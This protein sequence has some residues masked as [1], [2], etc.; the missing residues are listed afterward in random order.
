MNQEHPKS[1]RQNLT[2]IL[3][4][5]FG[6][7]VAFTIFYYS[8]VQRIARQ[9]ENYIADVASQRA[10]LL[11]DLF[12]ENQAYIESAAIV[13]E[14]EFD[15]QDVR[16]ELLNVEDVDAVDGAEMLKVR[17]ILRTYEERFAFDHLRLIDLHGRDYTTG[18]QGIAAVVSDRDYFKRG[19]QG[20]TGLTYILDSKVTNERQ[21]GFYSPVRRD[22][23]IIG[24][25]VGFYGENF[26]HRLLSV[27][28]FE[29]DCD[30]LLCDRA[31]AVIYSTDEGI[32][33]ANF[34]DGLEQLTFT[35][36]A[37]RQSIARAFAGAGDTLYGY[38][39]EGGETVGYVA[40]IG[41]GSDFF[42]VLNFPPHAYANMIR[43]AN[44]NG[45]VLLVI[46]IAIFLLAAAFYVLRFLSQKKRLLEETKNSN[47]IHFAMSRLFENFVR[48]NAASRTYH[49][50][51]GMP[52]VGHIP[53]DGPY[54]VFA[55][56]LLERF[57]NPA[58]QEEAREQI[59]LDHLVQT[60]NRGTDI[61]SYNLHAPIREE[62]WFTYNF[63]VVSRD[64]E[65]RVAE[66]LVARQDITKLQ[67]KEEEIRRIL[68]EARDAAEK[69]NQAKTAFLSS[70][71]HDI[72]TPMNAI[73]GFTNIAQDRIGDTDL[74]RDSLN[75]IASS[76]Q[77]LLSLIND[78]LDMSKIES[79][80]LQLHED[81]RN[82]AQIVDRVADM[83]RSQAKDKRLDI[84]FDTDGLAHPRV[85]VDELR[86][87]QVLINITGNA[88][89]YT[90][91][92]GSIAIRAT[93]DPGQAGDGRYCYRFS[94]KDTGIGISEDYL[95][96]IFESFSRETTSTINKIQGTGLGMAITARL[97]ELMGGTI[98]VTSQLDVGSEFVVTLWLETWED[99]GAPA[100][101]EGQTTAADIDLA[102][103]RILLVE[104]NDI[105]AEIAGLVLNGFGME[106]ERAENGQRGLELVRER[107]D[108]WYDAVL[109][110]IQMPVMNGYEATKAIRRLP[111][112]YI[113]RLP[114]IAMSANAYEE[115]IRESLA[116][117][118]NGHIAK[119]FDPQALAMTLHRAIHR[120]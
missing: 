23:E 31:G 1:L 7:V 108:G 104:D 113:R 35:G 13:L 105:N 46:L 6:T 111:G 61:I 82:L 29:Y 44:I 66:F 45:A 58:E 69:G 36:S 92:G 30:V 75:K 80:K 16:A 41:K 67:E 73:I 78:I 40:Y 109:M 112:A 93:E 11:D 12:E 32:D 51:E 42:L 114:I 81:E 103:R 37:D 86:L 27:S 25:V 98:A 19:I 107:G 116:S 99:T 102:G 77:Y 62:E 76:G 91:E 79:G 14:T 53:N 43:N 24:L 119:P 59:S 106:M 5:I 8:N 28:L 17:D 39:A 95:P 63:I 64:G 110:D 26:I 74:V 18:E 120:Q 84:T 22:G 4:L 101:P 87:E 83:T 38:K 48:V 90:P 3:V 89:K 47:D 65:G 20:K 88:V 9:N 72:R 117:G 34:L 55:A 50:I 60:M 70:M 33:F 49:Y 10:A 118:M 52:D 97:V 94:V 54:D 100:V 56:D 68:Q 57:P 85:K 96:H 2:G 115:D 15:T 71:S 21:V